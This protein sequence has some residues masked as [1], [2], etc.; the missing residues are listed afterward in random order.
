M[1]LQIWL[2]L[3]GN[4]EN[5]GLAKV[6]TSGGTVYANGKIGQCI[7]VKT[8][9]KVTITH[10]MATTTNFSMAFWMKIPANMASG[11]VWENLLS[12]TGISASGGYAGTCSMTWTN[13]D[14]VKIWDTANQQWLWAYAGRN[15]QYDTWTHWCI[16]HAASGE[17]VQ[18]KIYIDGI[19]KGTYVNST[20]PL[21]ITAGRIE[22]GRGVNTDTVYYN[23]FRVYD[24]ALS[25]KEVKELAKGLFLHYKLDDPIGVTGTN[26]IRNGFGELG[27]ENWSNPS[28]IYPAQIPSAHPEIKAS[29]T[30][31]NRTTEYIP[32][33]PTH[34]YKFELYMKT[35]GSTSNCYPSLMPYDI[36]KKFINN[37]N[38]KNGFN[39]NT[40]T[41]LTKNLN[42]GD[43]KIY[44]ESLANWNANSGHYYNYAAIFG[45]R[46]STGHL[47]PDGEYTQITPEFGSETTAK[48]NLDK[49]NNVIT[50]NT[51]YSGPT[52]QS[53]THIC[54]STAG[55]TYY[56]PVGGVSSSTI[57]DWT[58][59]T[60]TFSSPNRLSSARFLLYLAYANAYQAGI[61]LTDQTIGKNLMPDVSGY[62][63]HGT[64]GGATSLDISTAR[65]GHSAHFEGTS[66]YIKTESTD[67]MVQG[68]EALTVNFWVKA[69]SW[70]DDLRWFSCT[71]SGGFTIYKS[72][73]AGYYQWIVGTY[74][75]ATL[76]SYNYTQDLVA[77]KI[78]DLP[79]N[80][81][82]M[83]TGVYSKTALTTYVNGVQTSTKAATTYGLHYNTNARLFL[84]CEAS[85]ASPSAPYFNG[86]IS[87]FRMY[88]T[89]LSAEDILELYQTSASIDKN[90]NVYARELVE[91]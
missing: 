80:E 48:T 19:L 49:T 21:Q 17:G 56:Y 6:V 44:V 63:Y 89:A 37:Y 70:P 91:E 75:N 34:V 39:L 36:D 87:D 2:P 15:F 51:A 60:A 4:V 58:Y 27:S 18:G 9:T 59:K 71:E 38:S 85:T 78:A 54:A 42:S 11:T 76:S 29:F 61:K 16:T 24:H 28:Y 64:I 83:I 81:W 62:G 31:N 47:Y 5:Q 67:W 74:T 72:S 65:Y 1:S 52:I 55:S 7:G 84:G 3:N 86:S 43:T 20:H 26:L 88:S 25:E 8:S 45:Y 30:N 53:G 32:F 23:D 77:I 35:T 57:A 12:F 66:S 46:D 41:V 33:D 90:G 82:V 22:L 79:T 50:L 13:Y 40:M 69:A 14:A 73:Y 10:T 68:G